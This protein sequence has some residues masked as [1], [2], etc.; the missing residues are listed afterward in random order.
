MTLNKAIYVGF[1]AL[2]FSKWLMCDFYY[3]FI[4]KHFDAELLFT[5]THSLT[6]EINQKMFMKNFLSPNIY[7]IL[8]TMQ[9]I[10][11]FLMTLIKALLVK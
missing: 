2:E 9:K 5:D 8:V 10:Q 1:T 11:K 6:H 7:L 4:K 3:S